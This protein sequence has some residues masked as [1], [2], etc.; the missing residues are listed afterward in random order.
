[1]RNVYVCQAKVVL[2]SAISVAS[3]ARNPFRQPRPYR[4]DPSHMRERV[5]V[6]RNQGDED[7]RARNVK[8][9]SGKI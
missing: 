7:D 8:S 5:M 1:M 2:K 3:A 9:N 6:G 4:D